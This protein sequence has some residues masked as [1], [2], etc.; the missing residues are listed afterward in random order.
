MA[1]Y[2]RL[3]VVTAMVLHMGRE[4]ASTSLFAPL[5]RQRR[6]AHASPRSARTASTLMTSSHS[7]EA[8]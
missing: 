6:H 3:A 2:F 4:V 5:V 7:D 1:S 8:S